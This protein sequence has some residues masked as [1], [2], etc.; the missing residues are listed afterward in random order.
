MN[1]QQRR[2][3]GIREPIEEQKRVRVASKGDVVLLEIIGMTS[4]VTTH[5]ACSPRM[6]FAMSFAFL[7]AAWAAWTHDGKW[8]TIKSLLKRN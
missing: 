1:R 5:A 3:A 6:A 4:K 2:A 8:N 7:K